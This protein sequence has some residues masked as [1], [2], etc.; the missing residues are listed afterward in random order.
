[1]ASDVGFQAAGKVARV[2]LPQACKW[3]AGASMPAVSAYR[4]RSFV[5]LRELAF[6][7]L[8]PTEHIIP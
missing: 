5:S 8:C 2:S 1:M 4:R 6:P 7:G 3:M